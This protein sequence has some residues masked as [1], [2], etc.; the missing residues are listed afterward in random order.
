[1]TQRRSDATT[2]RDSLLD[3]IRSYFFVKADILHVEAAFLFGSWAAGFPKAGSDVDLAVLFEEDGPSEEDVF[4]RLNTIGADLTGILR[5][6]VNGVAIFRDFR[7]PLLYYNAVIRGISVY[8]KDRP[9]YVWL[10][11][12]AVHHMEDFEIFGK[13]WQ[14]ALATKNLQEITHD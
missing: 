3:A 13:Q 1:M 12:E 5:A 14:I 11:N 8:V 10:V 4:D 2:T 6:E 9:R 7:K